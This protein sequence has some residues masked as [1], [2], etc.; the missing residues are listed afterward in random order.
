MKTIQNTLIT[1]LIFWA[2]SI[3]A[4]DDT[5]SKSTPVQITFLYPIGSNGTESIKYSNH[6]SFN[7]L[8]GINKSVD[9]FELAGLGNILKSNMTGLQIAGITNITE[10]TI[11][12]VQL[13]G[14]YNHTNTNV[15]GAQ[16]GGITNISM[17][18]LDGLQLAGINNISYQNTKGLQISG[19]HN[20]SHG[21]MSGAQISGIY[22]QTDQN[23]QGLQLALINSAK[24][25]TG[26]QIG[27]INIADSSN[28]VSIGLINIIKNGYHTLEISG[29]EILPL[30]ITLK[31][32]SNAFYNIY[33]TGIQIN[34]P[35]IFGFGLGFGSNIPFGSQL[36]AS[37][38][39]TA[40]YINELKEFDW[41]LNLLNRLDL[42]INYD[43]SEHFTILA[44]PAFNVHVSELGYESTG[45]F[46]TNIA[47]N[48]F[49]TEQI[50]QT[51]VQMWVG[52]KFG[53]RFNF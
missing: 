1:I 17:K 5:A 12:G 44:G 24:K 43:F 11:T 25:I 22:N 51:Q 14:I 20:W 35:Q 47:K 3:H 13:A 32:G 48:P 42:T 15:S 53:A 29:N 46:T 8:Y 41:K 36:S 40:N 34:N 31:S 9:G 7:I 37:I 50:N 28:G 23:F 52:A 26:T 10:G 33:T 19:I 49:Y 30:S 45:G 38:D 39:L 27:L 21:N 2:F 4:Q 18:G 6:F 16:I